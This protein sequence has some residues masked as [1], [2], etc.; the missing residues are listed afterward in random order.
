MRIIGFAQTV[1][2]DQTPSEGYEIRV[3]LDNGEEASIPTNEETV[4]ALIQLSQG[5]HKNQNPG[6]SMS[7]L[8]APEERLPRPAEP[9]FPQDYVESTGDEDTSEFGGDVPAPAPT[10]AQRVTTPAADEM[11]YPIVPQSTQSEGMPRPAFLGSDDEDG[12]QI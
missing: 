8:V 2:L 12:Q 1:R 4:Q 5:I 6:M 7:A 11:G 10:P 9:H 3:L